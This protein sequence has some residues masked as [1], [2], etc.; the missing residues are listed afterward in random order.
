MRAVDGA[1]ADSI[2]IETADLA[3]TRCVDQARAQVQL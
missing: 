3:C 2:M 1:A